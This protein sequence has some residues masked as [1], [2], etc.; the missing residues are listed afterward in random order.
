MRGLFFAAIIL[1]LISPSLAF[2]TKAKQVILIDAQTGLVLFQKN[3]DQLIGTSSMT[4]IMTVYR[5]L[6]YLRQNKLRLDDT[7][8]VSDMAW[9]KGGSKMF[10]KVGERVSVKDLLSRCYYTVWQ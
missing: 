10:V 9:R 8:L 4:K 7:L 6:E 2:T 5:V 3:A 1:G